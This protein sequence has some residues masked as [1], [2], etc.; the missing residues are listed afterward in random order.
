[1]N[2]EKEDIMSQYEHEY[3]NFPNQKIILHHFKNIDDNIAPLINQITSLRL[4]GQC[5]QAANL[6]KENQDLLIPY[7]V[8]AITYNTWEEEIYNTQIYARQ[9]KQAVHFDESEDDVD[10]IEGDI[11]VGGDR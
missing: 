9:R 8:D 11:W 6:V 5:A 2:N 4:Q 7:I 3:S 10:C 1:L